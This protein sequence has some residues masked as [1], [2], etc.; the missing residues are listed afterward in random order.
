MNPHILTL[1]S[2]LVTSLAV[3]F[4]RF[5]PV[6]VQCHATGSRIGFLQFKDWGLRLLMGGDAGLAM[7]TYKGFAR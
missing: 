5:F 7:L 2:A 1:P 3:T 6:F 4:L